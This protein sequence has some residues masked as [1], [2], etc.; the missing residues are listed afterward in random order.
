[1]LS[2]RISGGIMTQKHDESWSGLDL[3]P[4]EV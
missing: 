3:I 1:M 4:K 2:M